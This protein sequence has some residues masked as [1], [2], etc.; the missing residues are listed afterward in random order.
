MTHVRSDRAEAATDRPVITRVGPFVDRDAWTAQGWCRIE[1]ALELVGTR[2]AMILIREAFYGGRRFEELTR[3]TGLSEAVAAKRLK[4]LV[5]DGLMTQRPYR[6]PGSRTRQEYVLTD[7]GRSL[8]PVVVALMNWGAGLDGPTGG[9]ELVHADCGEPVAAAVRCA[10]G[11][12]V[13]IED[14]RARLTGSRDR[15]RR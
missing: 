5:E 6:E 15:S 11:H 10:A 2:S 1:R 7:R 4:Q 8:F 12:D 14:T 9:V 13:T 3:R